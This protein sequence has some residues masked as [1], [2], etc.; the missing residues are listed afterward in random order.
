[1]KRSDRDIQQILSVHRTAPQSEDAVRRLRG[2]LRQE[3]AALAEER[4]LARRGITVRLVLAG[5]VSLP[6]LLAF[7]VLI[8][9]AVQSAYGLVLPHAAATGMAV[10]FGIWAAV[11]LS[12]TYGSLPIIGAYAM[13]M[14]GFRYGS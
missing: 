5:I 13:K 9:W 6:L 4:A 7:N 3:T 14:K 12:V 1:M 10:L 11:G 2:A 8:A